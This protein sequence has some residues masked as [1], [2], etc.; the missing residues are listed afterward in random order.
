MRGGK[1]SFLGLGHF[2]RKISDFKT[3]EYEP[4]AVVLPVLLLRL[5]PACAGANYPQFNLTCRMR[6]LN[7]R[8][9]IDEYILGLDGV[10]ASTLVWVASLLVARD[11]ASVVQ[12][13]VEGKHSSWR[14]GQIRQS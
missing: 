14:T 13:E 6:F 12:S 5:G 4:T 10:S 7:N 2:V 11:C 3:T 8:G 1:S 9:A